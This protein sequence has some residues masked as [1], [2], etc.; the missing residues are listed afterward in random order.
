VNE[1][2]YRELFNLRAIGIIKALIAMPLASGLGYIISVVYRKTNAGFSYKASFNI[3]L[4]MVTAIVSLIM[5]VLGSN[6]ALSLGLVG[7]LS[8]IRFR[9]VLKDTVDMAF[10]FWAIAV[11]LAVG[12]GNYIVAILA[13]AFFSGL[14]I[15]GS[16]AMFQRL[17]ESDYI[18]IV[19][20]D[21]TLADGVQDSFS[22]IFEQQGV[23]ARVRSAEDD[24]AHGS[25][26]IVYEINMHGAESDAAELVSVLRALEGILKISLLSSDTNIFA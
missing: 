26:E 9:T 10:L 18:L 17:R 6:I 20:L 25:K 11:G 8:I 7:S 16:K 24:L 2:V 21:P 4:I 15:Y 1:S 22:S 19:Q 3:T 5:I 14:A 13:T 12:A 23:S